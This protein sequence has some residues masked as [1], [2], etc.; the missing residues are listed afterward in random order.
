MLSGKD[1]NITIDPMSH[2][3]NYFIPK[4]FNLDEFKAK[5][6]SIF[7][8]LKACNTEIIFVIFPEFP[9]GVYGK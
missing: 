7:A 8:K 5:V 9:T 1:L 2:V 3:V 4:K 6:E